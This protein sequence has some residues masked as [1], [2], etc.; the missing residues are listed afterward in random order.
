MERVKKFVEALEKENVDAALI[1][2][3]EYSSRPTTMYLSGFTGSFSF[4]VITKDSQFIVTDSRYFEQAKQQTKF[5]LVEHRGSNIYDT[6]VGVL[7]T[8]KPKV[9]GLEFSRISHD[10]YLKLSE[11]YQALY[12]PID[13][14]IEQMR[15]IKEPQE[16]EFIRKAIQI[17]EE[18]LLKVLPLV[19]E[20]V[21]EKDIAAELEYQM[22]LLGAD[23]IA[24]ETIVITGPRTAL[25]HGRASERRLRMN[26]PVLFDFGAKFNGYCAD[27]T[28]TFYF[29]KPD[30][31]FVKVYNTVF[32]A[33]SLALEKGSGRMTGKELDSVARTHISSCGLGEYFGHGLGHG[34]GLE[35]HEAPRVNQS[36]ESILPVGAVVTI[37]PGIYIEGKFGVRIEEDV[38]VHED[39]L[40][41]LTH[42]ERKLQMF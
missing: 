41:R 4:L 31:E 11:K 3:V 20:G 14:I 27:I 40:E 12:K 13:H 6:V 1:C 33:Q 23:G 24:F 37:E 22:K 9:V 38:V 7:E 42:L 2:N 17:S 19:K 10:M 30:E 28:R 36:N 18:A 34:L 16:V 25:P 32:E 35:V 29:G 15:M 8:I 21:A 39:H 26:E 5:T